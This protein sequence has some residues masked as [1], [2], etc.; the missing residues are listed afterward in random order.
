[1]TPDLIKAAPFVPELYQRCLQVCRKGGLY[2]EFGVY[3]GVSLRKIRKLMPANTLLYGFDSFSG[4]PEQW[5]NL[6]VG[7]F[8]TPVRVDVP[9]VELVVG[10]FAETLPSFVKTH[11]EP[12]SFMHVDCDLYSS[13]KV[14]LDAFRKQLVPGSVIMFDELFG[15]SGYEQHEYKALCET[16]LEFN[17]IGRWDAFRA[18]I[19]ITGDW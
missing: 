4:L 16:D 15:F 1:M 12:V 7:T 18:A 14:V 9:G 8:A 11:N 10:M 5:R 2:M 13:T 17:V 19:Q 3:H 6:S